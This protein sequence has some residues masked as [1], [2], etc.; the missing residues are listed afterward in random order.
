[1]ISKI[2]FGTTDREQTRDLLHDMAK[3]SYFTPRK[4]DKPLIIYGA[5]SLGKMAKDYFDRLKI[6]IDAV[7]DRRPEL[8]VDDPF[9]KQIVV[10]P[11]DIPDAQQSS[12]L[13]VLCVA[14]SPLTEV[15]ASLG[16]QGWTDIVP[17]YDI[18]EA[19]KDK[20]PRNNGWYIGCLRPHIKD[21]EPVLFRWEDDISRAHYMQFITW[22]A[23]REEWIFDSAPITT[24]NRYFIPEVLSVLHDHEVFVDVG[25]HHGEV[26]QR[27]VHE[28]K[29]KFAPP[30]YVLA[31]PTENIMVIGRS[32][33]KKIYAFEPDGDNFKALYY[34][35]KGIIDERMY[36]STKALGAVEENRQFFEGLG[37]ASQISDMGKYAVKCLRLDDLNIPATFI[38]I[39]VEGW[40]SEVISGGL[41]TIRQNRP[42]LAV[43]SYHNEDGLWHL[44]AQMMTLLDNYV[45]YFRLHAWQGQGSVIYAIPRERNKYKR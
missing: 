17:F 42:I 24:D 12:S 15:T 14:T 4:V 33:Y 13:I 25:A 35:L 16:E 45:F 40:E 8:Y 9:W 41:E 21:I 26:I 43:T 38:K 1:M 31:A 19:Y 34:N 7:V 18:T 29:N 39:H 28:V 32:V 5:G 20:S 22:H 37:Y 30:E 23:L 36:I 11:E 2:Y 44:P 6:P 27:F 3:T 10:L